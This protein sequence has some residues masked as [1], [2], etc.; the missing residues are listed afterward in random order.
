MGSSNDTSVQYVGS[1]SQDPQGV[2]SHSSSCSGKMTAQV[3]ADRILRHTPGVQYNTVQYLIAQYITVSSTAA[4][5]SS[6]LLLQVC[7]QFHQVRV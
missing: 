6:L 3:L 5:C 4:S 7:A 2:L 1:I